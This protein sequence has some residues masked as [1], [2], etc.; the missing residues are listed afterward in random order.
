[1]LQRVLG[2]LPV[3]LQHGPATDWEQLIADA[4]GKVLATELLELLYWRARMAVHG[5]RVAE[6]N[7]AFTEASTLLHEFPVWR[8]RFH[9]HRLFASD[10]SA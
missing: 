2:E 10:A 7:A 5:G 9:A 8:L 3:A 1:M 6:A 4:R